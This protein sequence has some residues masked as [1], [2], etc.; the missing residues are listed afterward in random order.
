M[1]YSILAA[2]NLCDKGVGRQC[3]GDESLYYM[4]VVCDRVFSVK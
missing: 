2:V 4:K 3:S 1:S